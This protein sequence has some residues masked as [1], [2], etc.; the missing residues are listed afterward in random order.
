MQV[1][2][3]PKVLMQKRAS[4]D[5][6]LVS[7]SSKKHNTVSIKPVFGDD[8]PIQTTWDEL[9]EVVDHTSHDLAIGLVKSAVI[10]TY[11]GVFDK[12]Y[13]GSDPISFI[14]ANIEE[15]WTDTHH[16]AVREG[17]NPQVVEVKTQNRK[18]D[19][20][21]IRDLQTRGFT[22]FVSAGWWYYD[23]FLIKG[24]VVPVSHE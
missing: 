8:D 16:Y 14:Q 23:Y 5:L 2:V 11:R 22:Q 9:I 6:W 12:N 17:V 3:A 1:E 24:E 10:G 21:Q 7:K 19:R 4:Q 20:D 15:D 13:R 18:V